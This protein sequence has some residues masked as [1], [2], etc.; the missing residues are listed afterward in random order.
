[1]A[2]KVIH[3]TETIG[4][5][6]TLISPTDIVA[7]NSGD[8]LILTEAV[9]QSITIKYDAY[10][11]ASVGLINFG[12]QYDHRV[13]WLHFDLE[14]LM[15]NLNSRADYTA[16]TRNNFYTFKVLFTNISTN[17]T[18]VWEFDGVNFEIPRGV[19]KNVGTYEMVLAIEEYQQDDFLGNIKDERPEMI[20]RFVTKPIRGKV[21]PSLFDPLM[22]IEAT[23]VETDQEAALVKP[24]ILCTLTDTGLFSTDEKELGQQYD[25]FIR[26]FKFNPRRITAHLNDFF[27]L[28]LFKKD[29][30]FY[31]SLFERT[32]A[33][34]PLDDYSV[35]HPI[36]AWIPT[37]V[38]QSAGT[39]QVSVIAFAG[40]V[41]HINNPN[42]DNGDY[43]FFVSQKHT[44]KVA[45]NSLSFE[46]ITKEPV[47]SVTSNL[48]TEAGEI[49]IDTNNA[50]YQANSKR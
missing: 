2:I 5:D 47:L 3:K 11:K 10:G 27:V 14:D 23:P 41:D 32:V 37:G 29:D 31:Y 22:E 44:M 9:K 28:L 40:N 6:N 16:R 1:M 36:I 38:Y 12:M 20:E 25:N 43:Y 42:E 30:L 18:F 46:D 7:I 34:D 13:T 45:R 4:I 8:S 33:D 39:W 17:E 48:L 50:I 35:S 19:T 21:Q 49:I 15:W 24:Q 26:Y